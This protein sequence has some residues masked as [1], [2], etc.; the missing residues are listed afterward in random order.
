MI[1]GIYEAHLPVSD[2]TES[3]R[4]YEKL[5]LELALQ[6]EKL[7]FFWIIKG[8]SWIGLWKSG[9]VNL[10]YHPS[11]RHIAF[12]IEEQDLKSIKAWLED[13][14]IEIRTAFKMTPEQQPL[15]LPNVPFEHA[16]IY[17]EDPD[18]N[19]IELITFIG[20]NAEEMASI[21]PYKDWIG[22]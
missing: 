10:P 12:R 15:V 18:G 5:G 16:A 13:R 1:K 19:S 20:T 4:F 17:F 3:I 8:E 21:V 2:L 6:N 7:A 9:Q 22:K 14:G 11:I